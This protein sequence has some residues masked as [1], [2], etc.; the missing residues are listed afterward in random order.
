ML[1]YNIESGLALIV[2]LFVSAE[3]T[4]RSSH[5]SALEPEPLAECAGIPA[6]CVCASPLACCASGSHPADQTPYHTLPAL[7][8]INVAVISIYARGFFGQKA[9]D[10]GRCMCPVW[11]PVPLSWPVCCCCPYACGRSA[12]P[13]AEA[14]AG[15]CC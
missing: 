11:L 4:V 14:G 1:Y 13:G 5:T 7:L 2:T 12:L 3:G 9:S 8:Q 15:G 10:G 6:L